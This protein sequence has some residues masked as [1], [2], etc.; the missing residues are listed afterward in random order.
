MKTTINHYTGTWQSALCPPRKTPRLGALVRVHD[1]P[2]ARESDDFA[3][4]LARDGKQLGAWSR[5][6]PR[7]QMDE[8]AIERA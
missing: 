3:R 1:A 6:L 2:D 7:L 8:Y 4:A 5:R